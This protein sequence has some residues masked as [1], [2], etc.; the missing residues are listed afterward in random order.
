M[1]FEKRNSRDISSI[2]DTRTVPEKPAS[3]RR[4]IRR[5]LSAAVPKRTEAFPVSRSRNAGY[6]SPHIPHGLSAG[7]EILLDRGRPWP[8]QR[9]VW[10]VSGEIALGYSLAA[11]FRCPHFRCGRDSSCF[12]PQRN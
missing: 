12:L 9:D 11:H 1:A 8:F 3:R 5:S 10:T 7:Q 4:S 6:D 2:F